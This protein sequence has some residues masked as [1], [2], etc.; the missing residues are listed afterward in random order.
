MT[1]KAVDLKLFTIEEPVAGYWRVT[2]ANPPINMLNSTTIVE[3]AE[4]TRAD[5]GGQRPEGSGLR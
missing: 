3:L 2:Y 1:D 4:I 5:R